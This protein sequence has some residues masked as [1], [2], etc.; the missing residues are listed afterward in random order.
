MQKGQDADRARLDHMFA[1]S[2]EI[3]GSGAAGIDAGRHRALPGEHFG[4][5]PEGCPAPIDM[6]VQIDQARRDD[7]AGNVA[8]VG[9]AGVEPVPDR[10]DLAAGE[11]DIRHPVDIL[12]RVDD[13]AVAEHEFKR[14]IGFLSSR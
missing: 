11:G 12:G 4:V 14:H 2:R 6:G 5:D 3:A 8:H 13:A 9:A 1:K 7:A 10:G